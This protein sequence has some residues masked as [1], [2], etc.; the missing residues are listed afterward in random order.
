MLRRRFRPLLLTCTALACAPALSPALAQDASSGQTAGASAETQTVLPTILVKGKRV[1]KGSVADTPLATQTT[2]EEIAKKEIDDL[3]DLGNTTEPGVSFVEATKSV[4]IRGLEDDRVLTTI[5]GIPIPYLSDA[6]RDSYGGAN[7]YDFASISTIDILRGADSSRA[8]S[9]ALGGAVLLRT[10]EPEDLIGEGRDWGGLART[11]Y[12]SSDN[13]YGGSVAVAK[14]IDN[15]SMLF[16]GS[17]KKGQETETGGDVGGYG[18]TRTE[19]DPMDY[20]RRNLLMKFRHELEGG[21]TIGMTAEHYD[22][23]SWTN[24]KSEQGSSYAQDQYDRI[25]DTTR[26]RVSL[27]YR[28]EAIAEDSLIDS[29]FATL[30]WQRTEREEGTNGYR[31]TAPIGDYSRISTNEEKAIG[32]SGYVNSDFSTGMLHHQLTAGGDASFFT[33]SQYQVGDDSC[34]ENYVASCMFYH[35]NQADMPDTDGVRLGAYVED[36][37]AIGSSA[38]SLTPGVRFDW[39]D[40][41]PQQTA[42]Y[43]NNSGYAGLPDGQSDMAISPKLRAG[44]QATPDIELFAQFSTGFKAPNVSQLYSNY[45][46]A[47]LYRQI[48]N[49]DLEAETSYGFEAGANLGDEDFGGRITAFTTRYKNFID[50]ETTAEAGYAYGSIEYFNRERVRISGIELRG[51]KNFANGF[52]VHATMSYARGTDLDTDEVLASVPP[53][54]AI[55]GVG[56]A[57]NI[58]GTDLSLVASSAVDEDSTATIKP[59]GYGIV[60]LT[61]WWE[62]EQAKGLRIQ[63]GVYNLF[64]KVYYDALEVK[65]ASTSTHDLAYYS[66]AGRTFKISLTQKF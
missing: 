22:Y 18:A 42:G 34:D 15:T 64:D 60:N 56:Y 57:T 47:P 27:D 41:S 28:Y 17:Y 21:H 35:N 46:N 12:D 66:E 32:F 59:A 29:A 6:V 3:D 10:L 65:D 8:G 58:W 33:T 7:S 53:L 4:N 36:R 61:G 13:S 37:I 54:K 40:Y 9:G 31:T 49:P 19:A 23:N 50:T 62:P 48:G 26:N 20:N 1:V 52:N 45:D 38:F 25:A 44:W 39:Y 51:N 16:Q 55:V 11:G 5:D 63:A 30:Y 24:L 43:E 14:K 2:A